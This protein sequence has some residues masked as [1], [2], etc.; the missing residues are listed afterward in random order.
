MTNQKIFTPEFLEKLKEI[1]IVNI[2]DFITNGLFYSKIC[3]ADFVMKYD[4]DLTGEETAI[5]YNL[6]TRIE[7]FEQMRKEL[8]H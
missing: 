2:P 1:G 5:Y 6:R 8:V 7:F 3:L 4:N